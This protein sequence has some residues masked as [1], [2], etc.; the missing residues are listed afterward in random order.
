MVSN[1]ENLKVQEYYNNLLEKV[2]NYINN[3]EELDMIKKAYEYSAKAHY[4]ERRLTGEDYII[5]PLNVALILTTV[6]ADYE[7]ICAGLLHDLIEIDENEYNEIKENFNETI[8][9]LVKGITRI[10]KLNFEGDTQAIIASNR[11]ILVGLT[12]DVRVII[13]KLADRLHNMRTLW[14]IPEKAQKEK[15]KET[16]DILTPIAHRLGIGSLKSELEDLS[17]RYYKPDIYFSIVEMLNKTKAERDR[18]VDEMI[19][20]VSEILNNKGIKHKIKG[21]S[22]SIYSIYKKLD[23]GK[24]F[25]DIYDLL[26]L[27]V[28]VDEVEECYQALGYIHAVYKPMPRRFKDYIAMPK[29]NMYQSLHTTVFGVHS[30]L[31][32]IQIRTYEMDE[33]A[34]NGIASHWSY[35]EKGSNTK[36]SLKSTMEQKLQFFKSIME[37]NDKDA[38]DDEVVNTL[39]EDVLNTSVYVFTPNGDVIELA[40]G[41]TPIDFAY[42]VHT[43]VGNK[44][45][46]AIVNGNIVPL[47]YKLKDNDIVKINTNN[48]SKGPSKE[49]MNIAYTTQ[50]KNKIRSYFNKIDKQE[51][52][53][54]GE[55][56]LK[57]ELR[58]RKIAFNDF[59][60]TENINKILT[61]LKYKD[62]NELYTN[63]GNNKLPL[64]TVIN[65]IYNENDTK[66]DLI[67]KKAT[68]NEV[69]LPTIKNDIVVRGIDQIKVNVASCCKPVPGDS[70]VGYIT[71]GNGIAVH[72]M[73]CPNV[74]DV[75]ERIIDVEWNSE[76]SKKYPTSLLIHSTTN[77]D[78]LLK[79]ITKTSNSNITVQSI[80]TLSSND[81]F[82]FELVVV[83]PDLEK[84]NKFI[85]DINSIP[86]II[87]VERVIK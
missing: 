62:L 56:L 11:K 76:I 1:L 86:D 77:K 61:E 70:I 47:D 45:V 12:E 37:L 67:L 87:D 53:K 54:N 9:D 42:R 65:I 38:S 10:N 72:R 49:W 36:A 21:R 84:L 43:N 73:S 15:A 7:T 28:Y 31:F 57:E 33:I 18:N 25:S 40:K 81:S 51:Y 35:K 27:R 41:S 4:G 82:A 66:E 3:E 5:H 46:G 69:V 22:K 20:S 78:V 75:E 60:S 34:E 83:V 85:T 48:N 13:I 39:K 17:L 79:I 80:N 64:G 63:L 24:K 74:K 32:E 30:E 71:K 44:M 50:A 6:R 55:E 52:L 68:N 2:S 58:K 8:A 59:L 14:A 19:N 26:A 23:K 29:A 16:L